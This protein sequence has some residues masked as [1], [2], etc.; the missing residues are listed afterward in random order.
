MSNMGLELYLKTIG[1][2]LI[3]TSVGDKYVV[4]KIIMQTM[5]YVDTFYK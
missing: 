1:I 3:R 5:Q 2:D 4:E